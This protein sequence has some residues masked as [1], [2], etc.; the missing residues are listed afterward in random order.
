MVSDFEHAVASL[1]ST[2]ENSIQN[3]ILDSTREDDGGSY[4]PDKGF[5]PATGSSGLLSILGTAYLTPESAYYQDDEILERFKRGVAFERRCQRESGLFDLPIANYDSPPDTAFSVSRI[6]QVARIAKTRSDVTGAE[7]IESTLKPLL[8]DA[9][10]GMAEGG[11]HT[12]N[13]RWVIVDALAQIH[14]I[15]PDSKLIDRIEEYLAE[16][17]DI[18]DDGEYTERSHAVYTNVVN[19]HLIGA[20]L[21][22]D[23]TE[24]LEPVR[25]SLHTM[26]DLMDSELRILTE[27][28][29]RQDQGER[30]VPTRGAGEFYFMARYDDDPRLARV[31]HGLLDDDGWENG[32]LATDLLSYFDRFVDWR[33]TDLQTGEPIGSVSRE[34]P[35]SGL[36]RIR[37]DRFSATVATKTRNVVSAA[38][39]D[40]VLRGI[41]I[42]TPYFGGE[43]IADEI[44][45]GD[46]RATVTMESSYWHSDLPGYWD[47][48]DRP[49]AWGEL[50]RDVR[51]VDESPDFDV[52]VEVERVPDGLD[53]TINVEG[54]MSQVPF[55]IEARF[56]PGG[57]IE[58]NSGAGPAGAGDTFLLKS[59]RA[60]Y[61]DNGEALSIGPGVNGHRMVD[62][63]RVDDPSDVTRIMLTDWAPFNRTV[64]IRVGDWVDL[65]D[66]PARGPAL[67]FSE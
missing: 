23:R 67:G 65:M 57:T 14:E 27:L 61:R 26:V 4:K 28:S 6:A 12:A 60:T 63:P 30:T 31:A 47:P 18:N 25:R 10:Q 5:A 41:Q 66:E 19:R 64:T 16:G 38:F 2:L 56:I 39:G 49:V 21:A 8:V 48:L 40:V 35:D 20:A 22:L 17:I 34:M 42:T 3:Q 55:A 33:E 52:S 58:L 11:F 9:G 50:E 62:P 46:Q 7:E 45:F 51:T 43:F 59:G 36:W 53:V 29:S 13:H 32:R 54:G 24:L 37:D 44:S 1:D 15:Y